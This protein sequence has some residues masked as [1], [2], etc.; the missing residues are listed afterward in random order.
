MPEDRGYKKLRAWQKADDLACAVFMEMGRPPPK[1]SWLVS[2]VSRAAVSIPANLAEGYGRGSLGDYLRFLDIALGSMAELEYFLHFMA[3]TNLLVPE[4]HEQLTT[5]HSQAAGLLVGL[6]K[7]LKA[8][9]REGSWDHSRLI[10]EEPAAYEMD[11]G[12]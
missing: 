5:L 7:S 6:S 4:S 9:A 8:K 3:R 1:P 2:Q 12:P 10:K 11:F